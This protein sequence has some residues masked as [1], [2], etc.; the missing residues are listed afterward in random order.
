MSRTASD[1]RK[2][3]E[4]NWNE[5]LSKYAN[6]FSSNYVEGS[7]P[8]SVFVGSYGYPKV[9]VGPMV[10]PIHGNTLSMDLPE[11]WIGKSLEDIV[12]YRL[13]LV[14]GIQAVTAKAPQGRY[15]ES[16]QELAMSSRST[17]SEVEFVKNTKPSLFVDGENAPFG[18]IGEIKTAK[19]SN[20]SSDKNIQRLFYDKDVLAYDAVFELYNRGIEVSKIQK[21]FSIGMFGKDR[22]LV[23]TKWS[24]TATDDIISKSIV[25][26]IVNFSEIDCCQIFTY[27]NLGNLYGVIMFPRRWMFE[28]QEAWYDQEG[29]IGFGS[30]FEDAKGL[31]HYPETAGAHFASRLAV[32][33]Y[34][35]RAKVQAG[36]M[37]LREIRPEYAVP[38]GV[39]QV[40]E[41]VRMALKQ[42]PTVMPNFEQGLDLVCKG[43]SVGKKEW[44]AR[45]KL[46]KARNQKSIKDYF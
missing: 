4:S 9:L 36:V 25:D 11:S 12:N 33:E 24:I 2:A 34:L 41:G 8:P 44:L 14:R 21:C 31:S 27:E 28:M 17:D 30:D 13:S 23:P 38:L 10:P 3:I 19:F 42:K 20:S 18:P 22:K 7:S 16:L 46:Q 1:I 26:E 32:A 5:Y 39:W 43:L 35:L 29:N 40:R 15:I 6:L 37:V 45:S